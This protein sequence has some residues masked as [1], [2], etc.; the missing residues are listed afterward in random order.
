MRIRNS[1]KEILLHKTVTRDG[2]KV[3]K[4][5]EERRPAGAH[6][7][8]LLGPRAISSGFMVEDLRSVY[9]VVSYNT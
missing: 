6:T 7:E 2:R 8:I 5:E 9:Q 3:K 1:G 4:K